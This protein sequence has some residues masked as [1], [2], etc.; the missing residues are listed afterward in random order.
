M[1]PKVQ[2]LPLKKIESED[3]PAATW[4]SEHTFKLDSNH[5]PPNTEMSA[6]IAQKIRKINKEALIDS[7]QKYR[8]RCFKCRQKMIGESLF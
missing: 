5:G 3:G 4:D 7:K 6:Y 8:K 1:N 2:G